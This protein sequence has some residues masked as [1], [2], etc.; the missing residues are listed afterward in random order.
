M[1]RTRERS[2]GF[3]A[4]GAER[5]RRSAQYAAQLDRIHSEVLAQFADALASSVWLRRLLLEA[6]MRRE[7]ARR[8]EKLSP[9]STLYAVVPE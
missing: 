6:Q 2:A 3:V 9:S 7:V 1:S 5:V 8:V 4:D